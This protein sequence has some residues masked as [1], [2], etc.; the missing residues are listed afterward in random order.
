MKWNHRY[1]FPEMSFAR[2]NRQTWYHDFIAANFVINLNPTFGKMATVHF[3][4][5]WYESGN[6]FTICDGIAL[7]ERATVYHWMWMRLVLYIVEADEKSWILRSS[8]HTNTLTIYMRLFKRSNSVWLHS[9][10]HIKPSGYH[11]CSA[12]YI[13]PLFSR[14]T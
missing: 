6:M 13:T 7:M 11:I 5:Q 1:N 12:L 3:R 4:F 8:Q 9:T 2:E 14:D 10:T